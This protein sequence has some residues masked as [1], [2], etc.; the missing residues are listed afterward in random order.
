MRFLF[1]TPRYHPHIGGVE[2][3]AKS[4]A[5]RLVNRGHSVTVLCGE[6]KIDSPKEEYVNGVHV[7]SW[8]T[9]SSRNAYYIPRIRQKLR[10]WL[11]KIAR[12]CDVIHFHS[13]HS[14]LTVYSLNTL[15]KCEARRVL[16]PYY[17][18]TGHTALRRLLWKGWRFYVKRALHS[19]HAVHTVSKLEACLV[20]RDFVVD[21]IPIENGVDER[22][23]KLSWSPS[24]Y[25][26]YSGRIERYKNVH[27]LAHIVKILNTDFGMGLELKVFGS[28]P[29]VDRLNEYLAKI[30]IRCPV[31]PLQ[32][33]E[34]YID[35]LSKASLFGLL[36][37]KES[38]PQ[39]INEAN[40][41]GVPV[42]V[43]EPWGLNF[44]GRGRTLITK[45]SKSDEELAKEI[46]VF[47]DEAKEQLRSEVP[48]W[49]QVVDTYIEKLYCPR[50]K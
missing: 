41:I 43:V 45:L 37:E 9:W 20:K 4:V 13:V 39:S 14:V 38:Y 40:A 31:Y 10:D 27:R 26:M 6:P 33:Y 7:V 3:V 36:S 8:P 35:S 11:L 44:S 48:T 49:S 29:F 47:L 24:N 12:E 17:H 21:A 18:G 19:V 22:V 23:L 16:T 25:V 28:G 5:E 46:A 1:V 32:P 30:G 50:E 42:L 15:K 2:Y 34:D